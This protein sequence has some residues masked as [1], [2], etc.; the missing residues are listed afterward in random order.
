MIVVVVVVAM[1]TAVTLLVALRKIVESVVIV[2]VHTCREEIGRVS[3]GYCMC[4]GGSH[5]Y[6]LH[7]LYS[8]TPLH[9]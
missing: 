7:H 6:P 4:V 9:V 8:S 2:L 1:V 3:P 5:I